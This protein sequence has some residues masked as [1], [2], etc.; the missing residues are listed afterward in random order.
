MQNSTRRLSPSFAIAS[1]ITS[2][3]T[4]TL[5]A[6]ADTV[7][8]AND[9]QVNT[10]GFTLSSSPRQSLTSL[11]RVSL[12]SDNGGINS[13][14]RSMWLGEA[15]SGSW[16]ASA[17]N[18]TSAGLGIGVPKSTATDEIVNLNLSG[19]TIGQTYTVTFDLFIGGSWDGAANFFGFYGPDLWYFSVDGTRL[20]DTMFSN[21]KN[22]QQPGAPGDENA[23]AY[24]PQRY[25]DTSYTT[26]GVATGSPQP[27]I[28]HY[29]FEGADVY[30]SGP[31]YGDNYG[32]Y[33]FGHGVGNPTL[34]FTATSSTAKLEWAR[35]SG[36]DDSSDE[37]WALGNVQAIQ[38]GDAAA[39]PLPGAFSLGMPMF[40]AAALCYRKF[41]KHLRRAPQLA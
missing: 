38:L 29:R 24:S 28:D 3:F 32:I 11:S 10:S 14:N 39:T 16:A 35:Y 20:V 4:A 25:S 15:Y 9:F 6:H 7:I 41:G 13:V 31:S 33:Y 27:L 23:G 34:S 19:L 22:Y 30:H 12:P 36:S 26:P 40:A 21:L 37:F 1:L 18:P 17:N 5:T 8:F 2:L